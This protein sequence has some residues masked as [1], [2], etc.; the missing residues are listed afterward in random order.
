MAA[1]PPGVFLRLTAEMIAEGMEPLPLLAAL[2]HPLACGGDKAGVFRGQVRAFEEAVLRGVRPGQGF[3]GLKAALGEDK[4]R[5]PL[6][7]WLD[8]LVAV[9]K[10]FAQIM[11]RPSAPLKE[12]AA[13]HLAFAEALTGDDTEAGTERLWRGEA[14]EATAA[15]FAQLLEAAG[16]FPP[17]EPATYTPLLRTLMGGAMVRPRFGR[18]PRLHVWGLLEARLQQADLVVLGGLNEG[19]WPLETPADSWMS[20]PMRQSFG[21]PPAEVHMGL[22]A[23]DFA[24]AFAAP[25][26]VMTRSTRVAGT[27]TVPSRWLLR[28][29]ALLPENQQIAGAQEYLHWYEELD[30][31]EAVRPIATPK[32]MPPVA[33]RPRK[34]Y[35]TKIETWIRDPYAIYARYILGLKPLDPLDADPGAAERGQFIHKA[36]D[37]FVKRFPKELPANAE[38]ELLVIGETAFGKALE[39]PSVRALWWPRFTRIAT[40]FVAIERERRA[41][42]IF[43]LATEVNGKITLSGSQGDFVLKACA[44]RIDR[45]TGGGI[46]VIDYKTGSVPSKKQVESGLS[47]QLPLE[48]AIAAAGGFEGMEMATP[49]VLLYIRLTGRT[50]PG[51]MKPIKAGAMKL[52]EAALKGLR[53]RIATFD[54]ENTPYLSRLRP[55]FLSH[56]GDYDHLARVKEWSADVEA[57]E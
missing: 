17:M 56:E 19:G 43:P 29:E 34:L 31:P 12:L 8:R 3:D 37:A 46:A 36:L 14:G 33:A 32:P 51:E 6:A 57:D 24:Q 52:A 18:H 2:K 42:G 38:E 10:P 1:T 39:R 7:Q 30:A 15:F 11:A 5:K 27:P 4:T 16:D 21:L 40:W 22:S 49:E 13:A 54:D 45:M 44:D 23:H 26:V 55:M 53:R 48:A 20:Q 9:A 35:V 25:E 50:P 41:E 28:I 47:P